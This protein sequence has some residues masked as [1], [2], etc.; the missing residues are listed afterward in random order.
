MKRLPYEGMLV[1][2]LLAASVRAQE[3]LVPFDSA[4]RVERL[5][6]SLEAK[7]NLFPEF[8]H[9]VEAAL[10]KL[11]DS[12]YVLEIMYDDSAGRLRTRRALTPDEA[13][14][15][16][17][18]VM[19]AIT[20]RAPAA[21]LDQSGRKRFI[22]GNLAIGLGYHG[23]A[24][25]YAT[26]VG[27]SSAAGG[28]YLLT[29]AAFYFIPFLATEHT[30]VSRG[31]ASLG[32]Y[33]ASRGIGHGIM[34][35]LVAGAEHN[36]PMLVGA[37]V[38]ASIAEE[39]AAVNIARHTNLSDGDAVAI[40]VLGD[41]GAGIG[42]GMADVSGAFDSDHAAAVG[43][44]VLAGSAAGLATGGIL[45]RN[46]DYTRGDAYVVRAA[47]ALGTI[48]ALTFTTYAD[49]NDDRVY[50]ATAMAGAVG[51]L[52]LG[53]VLIRDH[54]FSSDQGALITLGEVAGGL[55][56]IG[57]VTLAAGGHEAE[58]STYW[59]GTMLGAAGGFTFS[60][61]LLESDASLKPKHATEMRM[62]IAPRL[63]T[64]AGTPGFEHMPLPPD[65]LTATL[66]VHF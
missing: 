17:W 50:S 13:S 15:L 27:S 63:I 58:S 35:G 28:L 66:R 24:I 4:G 2:C 62:D 26:Q 60:Y 25:P 9:F 59:T 1:L 65:M 33:G 34:L 22:A 36:G 39:V 54:D 8:P 3:T 23:W 49:P 52:A 7:L 11:P 55:F 18:R 30:S 51:G 53:H 31:T 6:R 57:M 47:G 19:Q 38:L 29:A 40:G 46:T 10:F 14:D 37:G 43:G 21:G 5:D 20:E 12:S 16:R 44:W 42:V 41:F 45:A 64:A 61:L 56:G 32:L 48:A